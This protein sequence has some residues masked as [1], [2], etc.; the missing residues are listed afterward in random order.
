MSDRGG[1]GRWRMVRQRWFK[2]AAHAFWL[3]ALGVCGLIRFVSSS[4]PVVAADGYPAALLPAFGK[5]R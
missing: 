5:G 3:A 1:S 2:R 4:E